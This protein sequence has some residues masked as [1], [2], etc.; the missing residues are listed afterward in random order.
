[1]IFVNIIKNV[2]DVI[3]PGFTWHNHGKF[4]FLWNVFSRQ[5]FRC[6]RFFWKCFLYMCCRVINRSL[7]L[8]Y[9][10]FCSQV[11]IIC[12]VNYG[13]SEKTDFLGR[14]LRHNIWYHSLMGKK[15]VTSSDKKYLSSVYCEPLLSTLGHI[16][17]VSDDFFTIACTY[18]RR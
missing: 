4:H 10:Y 18:F 17:G 12:R 7:F 14:R 8:C 3:V 1:M 11:S 9:C 6:F 5:V 16:I 2:M 13:C 15:W